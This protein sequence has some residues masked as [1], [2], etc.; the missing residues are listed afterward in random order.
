MTQSHAPRR[1]P[2][3]DELITDDGEP[4]DSNRHRQQMNLL[5]ESLQLA[6]ND[7]DD[8][9][10]GG[11]MFLY[12]SETQTR[13]N[14]F[15]GPDVFVVLDTL[16]RD[17]KAWVVWEE[18]G[19]TPDVIIELLSES[20]AEVD[21]GEKKRIYAR[22]LRVSEYFLFDP[23]TKELS[24]FTL[25][26][27]HAAYVSKQPDADGRLRCERLGLFLGTAQGE[28]WGSN[29]EWLRWIGDNGEVLPSPWEVHRDAAARAETEAARAET[30]AKRA[31]AAEAEVARLQH[32]LGRLSQR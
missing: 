19:K 23:D 28:V 9:F 18:D 15:R 22:S 16:R 12:F 27:L 8:F 31:D 2:G 14:T 21:P 30:E 10:V 25:D 3:V 4:M 24:G 6:W 29:D 26:P 32:E 20:T 13:K 5:I 11:N 17:R 1:L 7:R